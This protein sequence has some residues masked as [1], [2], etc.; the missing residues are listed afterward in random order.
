MPIFVTCILLPLCYLQLIEKMICLFLHAQR[1]EFMN[2]YSAPLH[3]YSIRASASY[4]LKNIFLDQV[5]HF[6]TLML[7]CFH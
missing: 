1:K 7:N 2:A 4:F 6:I 3:A 5:F